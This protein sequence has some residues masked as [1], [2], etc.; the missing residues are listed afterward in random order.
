MKTLFLAIAIMSVSFM[1][2]AQ[3]KKQPTK[4]LRHAVLFKFKDTSSPEDVKKVEDAFIKAGIYKSLIFDDPVIHAV[5]D[6]LGGWVH[7]C[8]LPEVEV[9]WW[10]KVLSFFKL[11]KISEGYI[12]IFK[13]NAN[14]EYEFLK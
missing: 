1:S 5:I 8:N 14:G 4:M 13:K 7:Y 9:K 11:Y 2:N 6:N 3:T 12:T 10:Q